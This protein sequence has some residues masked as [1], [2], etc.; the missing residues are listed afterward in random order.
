MRINWSLYSFT[1]FECI[2]IESKQTNKSNDTIKSTAS[3]EW[4][5]FENESKLFIEYLFTNELISSKSNEM[6]PFDYF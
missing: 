1:L 6:K 5:E 4:D 2:H 3:I